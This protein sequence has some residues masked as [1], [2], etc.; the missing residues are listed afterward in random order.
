MPS[1]PSPQPWAKLT[2]IE[3]PYGVLLHGLDSAAMLTALWHHYLSPHQRRLITRGWRLSQPR[4]VALLMLLAAL[5]DTGKI[6]PGWQGRH[7]EADHLTGTPGYPPPPDNAAVPAHERATHLVLPELLHRI[8]GLPLDDRPTDLV[9][10]QLAQLAGAHHG[11]MLPTLSHLASE[12]TD[13]ATALPALGID[14]W[15][16]EREHLVRTADTL[17]HHPRLPDRPAPATT[18][19]LTA[20]LISLADWLSSQADWINAR[21]DDWNRHTVTSPAEH[22]RRARRLAPATLRQAQ[23]TTPTTP[24]PTTMHAMFP[25]LAGHPLHPLQ[26]DIERHLPALVAQRGPGLTVIV[27]Q[28]GNGKTEAGLFTEAVMGSAAGS[29]GTAIFLPTRATCEPMWT[30]LAKRTRDNTQ[31]TAPTGLVHALARFHPAYR[32]LRPISTEAPDA[33]LVDEWLDGRHRPLLMYECAAT[34]DQLA[35]AVLPVRYNTA[36]WLGITRKTVVIDEAHAYGPYEHRL[37]KEVLHWLAA[38]EIPVVLLSATLT[39]R[40]A[41]D[42]V[43]AYRSGAGHT[44]TPPVEIPYPGWAYIDHRT[45]TVTTSPTIPSSRQHTLTVTVTP[46]A[47]THDPR[48]PHGRAHAI[49]RA[50]QPLLDEHAGSV[51]I[52][53]NTIADAQATHTLLTDTFAA[54]PD[55]PELL[56]L[57]A[58]CP[59]HRRHARTRTLERRTSKNAPRL[60]RPFIAVTTQLAEQSLDIDTDH[61]ITDLAPYALLIQ[62]AGRQYRHPRDNRPDWARHPHLTVL[63]P[64]GP[65]PHAW[66]NVYDESLLL[67]TRDMLGPPGDHQLDVPKGIPPVLSTVYEDDFTT[68]TGIN[69]LS[70][71]HAADTAAETTAVPRPGRVT[72]LRQLSNGETEHPETRLGADSIRV[73]PVYTNTRGTWLNRRATQPLP[74]RLDRTT[75]HH[76]MN[77]TLPIRASLLH[78]RSPDTEP[79]ANWHRVSALS[80]VILLPHRLTPTGPSAYRTPTTTIRLDPDLGLVHRRERR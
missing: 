59:H 66:L 15:D 54:L 3:A 60:R 65:L 24:P 50:L 2:G 64:P 37:T 53:C 29:I 31:G 23:L 80:H 32:P 51:L 42:L 58:E 25:H 71:E 17:L 18:A 41:A 46:A 68:P 12:L 61:V 33:A 40:T 75:T 8:R 72:D 45:G 20:G 36:R 28:T 78:D 27:D 14:G 47:H 49:L 69:R 62:R 44:D 34:W 19:I 55:P 76:L 79:P 77:L 30:R 22:L 11:S 4:T 35:T 56:L 52:V 1:R 43:H 38:F 57:H 74:T 13:P 67:R 9:A 26:R 48:N 70:A 73:L 21:L 7:P 5:H 39:G 6:T 10:Q 63:V 16:C